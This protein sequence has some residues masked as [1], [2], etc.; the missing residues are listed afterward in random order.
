MQR[1]VI[2]LLLLISSLLPA[3]A[4]IFRYIGMED[5]LSSR[6]VIS[7]EQGLQEYIWILTHKG[8]DRYDGKFFNHYKLKREDKDVHFYPDLNRLSIDRNNVLWEFG[9]DGY[10]FRFN[11][12]TGA[13]QIRFDLRKTFPGLMDNPITAV[14][15]DSHGVFWFCSQNTLVRYNSQSNT[16]NLK[17]RFLENE[18]TAIAEGNDNQFFFATSSSIYTCTFDGDDLKVIEKDVIPGVRLVNYLY[19]HKETNTLIINTLMNGLFLYDIQTKKVTSL[20]SAYKDVGVNNI[21]PYHKDSNEVLIATDGDGVY[22]LNVKTQ[23]LEHFLKENYQ[24]R[25]KMNGSII[26]DIC[27]D[28][29]DRIWCVIYPTGLTIYSERYEAYDW[30]RR[31]PSDKESLVDDRIN[32]II[33]DSDGDIWFAT[34]NGISCYYL[35][36][37]RWKTY[38][39]E[40]SKDRFN[41]NRIFISLCEAKPGI[42]LA[43]GYMSGTYQI[44]KRSGK[45]NYTL[46]PNISKGITPDKYIRSIYRDREG[47]LWGG[48]Y[49]SLRTYDMN[50]HVTQLYHTP[51]PITCIQW[52]NDNFLWIG[53]INGLYTFNKTTKQMQEYPLSG[54]AGC[55]NS[56]Y[57]TAD[58]S[59]AYVATYGNGVY[60]IDNQ[61]GNN[62]NY[63]NENCGL[64]TNNI[65]SIAPSNDGNYFFGTESGLALFDS[66]KKVATQWTKEQGLLASSFNQSAVVK[67]RNGNLIFGT[68]EGAIVIA[69]SMKLPR[70]FSGH[71][72]L[73]NLHIMYRAMHP[74]TPGSP[75]TDL[76]NNTSVLHLKYNQNTFSLD[77][78]SINYDNPSNLIYSWKLEGFYDEWSEASASNLIRYTNLS[79]GT[80]TL[81]IRTQLLDNHQVMEERSLQIIVDKPFWA[82]YWAYLIYL[83]LIVGIIYGF[84]RW[85]AIGK[86]RRDSQQKIN[87]F[88]QTAHDIRTPLTLIKAPLGE[89]L[90]KEQLSDEGLT[91]INLAIQNTDNLSELASNLMN[92]QKE[93]LYSARLNVERIELNHYLHDYLKHFESYAEQKELQLN[94]QSSFQE[95]DVWL[96]RNKMDSILRNLLTNALKYTPKGGRV[97]VKADHTKSSWSL[98]IT[99]TGIGISKQDQRKLFKFLFRGQNAT[100]QLIT[101]SGVGMLL[102]RRLIH[103]HQ[104]KIS[105]ISKENTGTS[106]HLTF[107][108]KSKHYE[109]IKHQKDHNQA[110]NSSLQRDHGSVLLED[111]DIQ[112]SHP[113]NAPYI[114]I[115]ED[116]T[117]LR[118]FLKQALSDSYATDS[119]TNGIEALQKIKEQQPDLIISDVMM[120]G[121]NGHELCRRVK[122]NVETSHIPIILLTALGDKEDILNGL[123]CK[124]DQYIVKPFDL[125]MLKANIFNMLENRDHLRLQ[126]KKNI[127]ANL[128]REGQLI[129]ESN[130]MLSTL[131][132]EFILQVTQLVKEGL[133]KGLNVD[134]LCA[135]LNMSRTSFYHK[136]KALTGLAPAELIR[137]I[138]MEEAAV[139]LKN[140]RYS[141]AEVSTL[142]GF[143]DPKYFTDTFKKQYGMTPSVYQKREKNQEKNQRR[144]QGKDQGQEPSQR[145]ETNLRESQNTSATVPTEKR[146]PEKI[147]IEIV[148]LDNKKG[149]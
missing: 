74:N 145:H 51:Y 75:L 94:Y 25:N 69:D 138:R 136:I 40:D 88:I 41:D 62:I 65:Y 123:E 96:D 131:D 139:L 68:N 44:N 35:K 134:S 106:F 95:L 63:N 24:V 14:Y 118:I 30:I 26:K 135:S 10:V 7:I 147:N 73:E 16:A 127:I 78:N 142:L 107:P 101:G 11:E 50:T 34:C 32:A 140:Q 105:F 39:S 122:D 22:R 61:N 6:R 18:V 37:K 103:N 114:L 15:H 5:G 92:F 133:S 27:I 149:L 3:S 19:R 108:L 17:E 1:V 43:G 47:L 116:N 42:I 80:Y 125:T 121:M 100:N 9:K 59:L 99:D 56:I 117:A 87:F 144:N 82:T 48:G 55:I 23:V 91:N 93:E 64:I 67:T 109:Y 83:I 66:K 97:S 33:Q 84:R 2:L 124:A 90:K 129:E 102:T 104:G 113:E 120:P 111:S 86:D 76:L 60:I 132:D 20:G 46:Q 57:Q 98:T 119:A 137:N 13:F 8:V 112:I 31:I 81:K 4:Q 28:S 89:I 146:E 110:L 115:V 45:V 21:I 130:E 128:K 72:I 70:H 12:M 54:E 29:S 126:L 85:V 52:K 58:D 77:V 141:I 49:Y 143:A 79:P 71:M 38:L 36:E 148:D 53:T